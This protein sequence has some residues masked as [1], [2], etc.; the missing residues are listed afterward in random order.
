[1]FDLGIQ[2]VVRAMLVRCTD[3]LPALP[4][5]AYLCL[6]VLSA[7]TLGVLKHGRLRAVR[8]HSVPA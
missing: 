6:A 1:M 5:A 2:P 3:L 8:A 7:F 4:N